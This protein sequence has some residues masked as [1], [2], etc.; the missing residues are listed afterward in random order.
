MTTENHTLDQL[1]DKMR[2]FM[3]HALAFSAA[4]ESLDA[5]SPITYRTKLQQYKAYYAA[6]TSRL[7][8]LIRTSK[9]ELTNDNQ[10][11]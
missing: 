3:I 7:I 8:Q 5:R 4:L 11:H 6:E 2:E 1:E 10:A 9:K